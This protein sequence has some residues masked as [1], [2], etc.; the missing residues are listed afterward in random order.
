MARP[1]ADVRRLEGEPQ[2]ELDLARNIVLAGYSPKIFAA[3]TAAIRRTE[4]RAVEPVEELSAELDTK[5][6]VWTKLGVLEEG[7]V[8]VLHPV[9]AY[10]RLGTRIGTITVV[11]AGNKYGSVVPLGQFLVFGTGSQV[12]QV[13]SRRPGT[14]HV[15][16]TGTAERTR[17][18]TDDNREAALDGDDGIDAPSADELIGNPVQVICKLLA[19]A[20]RHV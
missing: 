19:L 12:R 6:F 5:P 3:A 15:G 9:S 8:N 7:K 1:G 13:S 17:A 20:N 14:A 16:N 4:L 11:R 2:R 10:V 18:A